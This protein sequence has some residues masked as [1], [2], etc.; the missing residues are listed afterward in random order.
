MKLFDKVKNLFTEEVEEEIEK[1][2]QVKRETRVVEPVQ[3]KRETRVPEPVVTR[4][5][6]HI[7][8]DLDDEEEIPVVK[9]TVK[10]EETKEKFVFPVYFDDKDFDDLEKPK[11]PEKKKEIVKKESVREIY[12]GAK[13]KT[14]PEQK[15]VFTPSPIISPVYGVLD[16]NYK[17]DDITTKDETA[18]RVINRRKKENM[19]VDDI[20][21]KAYGTLE[22]ELEDTLL[23][24]TL[25]YEE[26]DSLDNKE[27]LDMFNDIDFKQIDDEIE[28]K[29]ER[30]RKAEKKV[31]LDEK[32]EVEDEDDTEVLAR[33]LEEQKKKLERINQFMEENEIN[34]EE[35]EQDNYDE[36]EE[37]DTT[38][39]DFIE[40]PSFE[41]DNSSFDDDVTEEVI[42]EENNEVSLDDNESSL[43]DSE[44]FDLID[45]MYEKGDE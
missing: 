38:E 32:I 18:N 30:F 4:R 25:E 44:L 42:E 21:N 36:V 5:E 29:N 15:K 20:R 2:V 39:A 1:P 16:K 41:E 6:N 14:E 27:A 17:K 45:S 31:L 3:V 34:K 7:S 23:G 19:T 35:N 13:I 12:Q 33:K 8:F 9:E 10:T 37:K 26:Y 43:S 22:N 28:E 11:Q 40:N 24:N